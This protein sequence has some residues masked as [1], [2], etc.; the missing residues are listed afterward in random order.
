MDFP[1]HKMA[2]ASN[3]KSQAV[4]SARLMVFHAKSVS[5]DFMRCLLNASFVLDIA[6]NAKAPIYAQNW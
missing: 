3:A 5:R 6:R 1:S 2:H 4:P